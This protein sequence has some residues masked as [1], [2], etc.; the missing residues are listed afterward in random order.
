MMKG[1]PILITSLA[2][3]PMG[4]DQQMPINDNFFDASRVAGTRAR[5]R[6]LDT[7]LGRDAVEAAT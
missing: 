1:L 7:I 3:A 5:W 4:Q 2:V 6:R